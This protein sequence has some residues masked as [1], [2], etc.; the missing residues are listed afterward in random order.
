MIY[1][2]VDTK[3]PTE[4]D[5]FNKQTIVPKTDEKSQKKPKNSKISLKA[6]ISGKTE[7]LTEIDENCSI[8]DLKTAFLK[9]DN[10]KAANSFLIYLGRII[11]DSDSVKES[12]LEQDSCVH[13]IFRSKA[14]ETADAQVS[15][16]MLPDIENALHSLPEE[17]DTEDL[18]ENEDEWVG[19]G[20][21]SDFVVGFA[22]GFVFGT[23]MVVWTWIPT[24][25]R[26]QKL[27]I[28]FG[29][30]TNILVSFF[31]NLNSQKNIQNDDLAKEFLNKTIEKQP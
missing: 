31:D 27:G 19:C 12:G 20:S 9:G 28:M 6:L 15:A 17:E 21:L 14:E 16:V 10:Q 23:I 4:L 22:L 3:D 2:N 8:G 24:S 1:S 7:V 5:H 29:V 26:L 18:F 25:T 30:I 11:N 13:L